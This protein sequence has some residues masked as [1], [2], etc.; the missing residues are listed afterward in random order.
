[1]KIYIDGIEYLESNNDIVRSAIINYLN[2]WNITVSTSGTT[3]EPKKYVHD[4]KLMRSI[5][6]YNA[7]YLDLSSNSTILA[8]YNPRGIGF[9]SMSLYL[10]AVTNCDVFYETSAANYPDKIKE[11]NPTYTLILPNVWK[12]WHRHKKWKSLDLSNLKHM[13]VGSDVTPNGLME[14]LRAKGAQKVTTAYGSTEV[15]PIIMST[16]KQ[17]IYHFNNIH[18]QIDYKNINHDDGTIEWACKWKGQ[19]DYWHSG[20]LIEYTDDGEFF[21]AGRKHNMFKMENCGDRVYPEQI[22]KVATETGADLALCRK[23][24]SRCVLYYTG[25]M[26]IKEFSKT[27]KCAYEIDPIKVNEIKIDDNLRKVKRNQSFEA[28]A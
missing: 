1:M 16:E 13:Q 14:D 21:F 25:D 22:E 20:D 12:T 26:N 17:D 5:A 28:T 3:G 11:I 19:S 2:D 27:H 6:E 18:P 7:E 24:A 4:A 8:L 9:T 10:G 23:V 15:P